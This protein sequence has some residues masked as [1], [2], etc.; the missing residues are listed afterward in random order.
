MPD[1]VATDRGQVRPAVGAG[2]A[3]N[4][5]STVPSLARSLIA[6]TTTRDA[7]LAAYRRHGGRLHVKGQHTIRSQVGMSRR[8]DDQFVGGPQLS[9]GSADPKRRRPVC[10]AVPAVDHE[11]G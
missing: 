9:V 6:R 10:G 3:E 8:V 4:L 1:E 7:T 11:A 2:E 5:A